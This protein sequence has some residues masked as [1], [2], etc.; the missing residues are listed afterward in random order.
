MARRAS[1]KIE[2][3]PISSPGPAESDLTIDIASFGPEDARRVLLHSSGLHGV[4]GFAGSAI[5]LQLLVDFPAL[6]PD[7]ALILVHILNPYGMAWLRRVNAGN[8]DLNRNFLVD[9]EYSGAP[10]AYAELDSFLN[11]RTPPSR[12]FYFLKAAWLIL[13]RG[14]PALTQAI[15]GGQSEYPR[16]LFFGGRKIEEELAKYSDWLRRRLEPAEYVIAMDVHTGLGRFGE[17]TL[18]VEPGNY[19]TLRTSFGPRVVQLEAE[20]GPAY[21]IC[22]GLQNLIYKS[23]LH[24]KIH[25]IGE[26]FGTYAAARVLHALREENRWHHHGTAAGITLDHGVKTNLMEMFCPSDN[27]WRRSVLDLGAELIQRAIHH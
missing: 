25:F 18:L 12:D 14:M 1:G 26:E 8:V 21:R 11:P 7:T 27:S 10:T 17:E 20:R 19:E 22:G 13:R 24:A 15:V 6:P 4:E 5:Q 3:I 23:A 16:G 9:E 2:T